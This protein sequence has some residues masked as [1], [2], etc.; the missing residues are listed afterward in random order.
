MTD[1]NYGNIQTMKTAIYLLVC[2]IFLLH[3]V[4][5]LAQSMYNATF[6]GNIS[7]DITLVSGSGI[8]QAVHRP[9]LYFCI[10]CIQS[11]EL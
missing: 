5:P 9:R 3:R 1:N 7:R 2:R 10:M 8:K 11:M 4:F 6:Y